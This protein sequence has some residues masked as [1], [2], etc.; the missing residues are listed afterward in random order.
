MGAGVEP[1]CLTVVYGPQLDA[2]KMEFLAELR[3][4]HACVPPAWMIAGDFNLILEMADK[5]NTNINRRNMGRFRRFVDELLLKDIYLHGRRYTWSNERSTPT[6]EKLDQVLVTVDWEERF[7]FCFLQP[8]SSGISDHC[9]LLLSTNAATNAKRRFHFEAW[10]LKLPG[11]IDV[12]SSAWTCPS[13]ISDP[14]T[15]LDVKLKN[16]ARA[17]QSWSHRNVGQI[18]HQLLVAETIVL[19]LDTAQEHR[20][21]LQEE[22]ALGRE[23]KC[24]KSLI[25]PIACSEEQLQRVRHILPATVSE[26]PVLYLGL[27]LTVGHLRKSDFQPLVDKVTAA[28]PTWRAPL[29]NRAGRLTT[30]RVTLSSICTHTLI[31]LKIPDWVLKEIDKRRKGFLWE[32][33]LQAKGGN[34]LVAWTTACRPTIFGGLGIPDLRLASFALR[35][36]WL[37]MQKTDANRPWKHMQ[38][39]FGKDPIL[40]QMFQ[41]SIEIQLGDG[42][43]ALFW[44]DKWYGDSSPCIMALDL[45]TLIKPAIR[46]KRTVAQALSEKQWIAD[47]AGFAT[48]PALTQYVNLWHALSGLH[49]ATGIEDK[50]S[51]RWNPSG[52][53]TARSAYKKG[54]TVEDF[55]IMM[56]VHC[57]NR[58]QKRRNTFSR[59]VSS[60][61]KSGKRSSLL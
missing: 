49:L 3:A 23:L 13:T 58:I 9:P 50:V 34:C 33:K 45:C 41:A 5:N 29:M 20:Q 44:N 46:K 24:K 25:A 30:V 12:V 61:G 54:D 28:I 16:T 56:P 51:W 11:Y 36:R 55:K 21:L 57:A 6:M 31:S 17:L 7:P 27:P 37:W 47:I 60:L 22:V 43:L 19:W 48:V 52:D 39:D 59:S 4:V 18:K 2:D 15:Q 35:L 40:Q 8:L 53:Y 14:F 10:W 1:W 26:F 38:L 32:G 42:N